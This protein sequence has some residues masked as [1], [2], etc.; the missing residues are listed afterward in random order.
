VTDRHLALVAR[1]L[2]ISVEAWRATL[3]DYRRMQ[4]G[5]RG[6]SEDAEGRLAALARAYAPRSP[7]AAPLPAGARPGRCVACG[8]TVEPLLARLPG[9]LVVG[10]C[11][12]CGQGALL[13]GGGRAPAGDAYTG[14]GYYEERDARGVGY[15]DY[16]REAAYREA[17]GD[18]LVARLLDVAAEPLHRL[19]EVGSGFGYTRAAAQRRGLHTD[20]V[21]VNPHAAAEAR[22]RYGLATFTGTLAERLASPPPVDAD[23][24]LYQFVLEHVPDV[25][26]ELA[27]ARAALR[28]GGWLLLVVPSMEA[29]EID[30]FGASYRSFRADHLHLFSRASVGRLLARAGFEAR[31]AETACSVHVLRG[32]L[33]EPELAALY[34]AGRGPDLLVI[35]RRVT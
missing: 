23:A 7:H 14:R 27:C 15:E 17:K 10:R 19:L 30:V 21:D 12:A 34:A 35:A 22:R 4:E 20:G 6:A 32:V 29:A 3:V 5:G 33:G 18:R 26:A 9:P 16:G 28:P 8:G 1:T 2:Q 25:A 11:D 13:D 24:V 31:V